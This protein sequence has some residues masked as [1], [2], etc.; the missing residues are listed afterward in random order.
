MPLLV[1]NIVGS[2]PGT[3]GLERTI[4]WP[5]DSKNLRNF[6]RISV[7]FMSY[8][9]MKA[10]CYIK[11]NDYSVGRAPAGKSGPIRSILSVQKASTPQASSSRARAGSLTV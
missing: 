4:V 7:D 2:L 5:L 9:R 1:N 3:S 8:G 10:A 11:E 6:S